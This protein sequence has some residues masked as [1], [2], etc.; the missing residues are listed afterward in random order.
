METKPEEEISQEDLAQQRK[1]IRNIRRVYGKFMLGAVG[2]FVIGGGVALIPRLAN[3]TPEKPANYD[4]LVETISNAEETLKI[5][6][7]NRNTLASIVSPDFP[8]K[9]EELGREIFGIYELSNRI[10]TGLNRAIAIVES[11]VSEMKANPQ[12]TAYESE[13]K[14]LRDSISSYSTASL[15]TF[16]SGLLASAG[17]AVPRLIK[18]NKEYEES[19]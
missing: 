14:R 15:L 13:L 2:S 10:N 9:K 18:I 7:S 6:H 19:K 17:W 4:T 1:Y 3:K 5:L 11:D 16:F 8:Y 12:L